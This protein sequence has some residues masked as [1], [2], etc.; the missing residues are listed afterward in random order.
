MT[1]HSGVYSHKFSCPWCLC[2]FFH[3]NFSIFCT[4][5]GP[6]FCKQISYG[7]SKQC[8]KMFLIWFAIIV[9]LCALKFN[10]RLLDQ[11]SSIILTSVFFFLIL[12]SIK[13]LRFFY[14]LLL[15]AVIHNFLL[16]LKIQIIFTC[17]FGLCVC[18]PQHSFGCPT[19]GLSWFSF[20]SIL[21]SISFIRWAIFSGPPL[22][23]CLICEG[24]I[25]I[26]CFILE[27][28]TTFFICCYY[29]VL[30]ILFIFKNPLLFSILKW[31][32]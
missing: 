17:L 27:F 15:L 9:L 30:Y 20:T 11:C 4:I 23:S 12:I 25:N 28:S 1:Y 2:F 21:A 26:Y 7:D 13:L 24:I 31:F 5:S 19:A 16:L 18:V 10:W 8:F 6:S 14:V 32:L 22:W 3:S 29:K